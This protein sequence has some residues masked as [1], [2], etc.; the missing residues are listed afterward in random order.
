MIPELTYMYEVFSVTMGIQIRVCYCEG[1]TVERG[2]LRLLRPFRQVRFHSEMGTI[3]CRENISHPKPLSV[4]KFD[5]TIFPAMHWMDLRYEDLVCAGLL[6][7]EVCRP[8]P[9]NGFRRPFA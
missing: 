6:C 7:A 9:K 5:Y 1:V 8:L 2:Y 3:S 4:H